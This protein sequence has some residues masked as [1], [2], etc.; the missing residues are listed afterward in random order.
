MT[1]CVGYKQNR[2]SSF[3]KGRGSVLSGSSRSWLPVLSGYISRVQKQIYKSS[4]SS[5]AYEK[6]LS[7]F[8]NILASVKVA[9]SYPPSEITGIW[10]R[11]GTVAIQLTVLQRVLTQFEFRIQNDKLWHP[12]ITCCVIECRLQI[13]IRTSNLETTVSV[14]MAALWGSLTLL[15]F[16]LFC[17][18]LRRHLTK[19]EV[20]QN[21]S[22]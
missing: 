13:T 22:S 3:T 5:G 2:M 20:F 8:L 18:H 1:S 10:L 12:F 9:P 16:H 17:L 7:N 21:T 19:W 15:S 11:H 4:H 6:L 14:K